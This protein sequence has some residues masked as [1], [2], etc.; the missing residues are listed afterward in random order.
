MRAV[1]AHMNGMEISLPARR[2][3]DRLSGSVTIFI[4]ID[5]RFE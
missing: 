5:G 3:Y 2:S 1:F 4:G